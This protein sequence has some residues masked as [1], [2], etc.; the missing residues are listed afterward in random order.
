VGMVSREGGLRTT[1]ALDS[2]APALPA[3]TP[4]SAAAPMDFVR[5]P[6]W[7]RAPVGPPGERPRG[8]PRAGYCR[9]PGHCCSGSLIRL[10]HIY[11][12]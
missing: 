6:L 1:G 7:Q 11:N 12:F 4:T 2:T 8:I 10:K 9:S 5:V 3:H